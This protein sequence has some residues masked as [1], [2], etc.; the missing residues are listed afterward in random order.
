MAQDAAV[1]RG[2]QRFQSPCFRNELL[3]VLVFLRGVDAH[4]HGAHDAPVQVVQRGFVCGEQ[5]GS[6]LR[7]DG[8][9]GD[10]GFSLVHDLAL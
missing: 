8:F 1:H 6:I 10:T 4:A 3:S 7:L 9:L 2:E 5:P